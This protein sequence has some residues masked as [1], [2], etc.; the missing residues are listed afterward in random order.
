MDGDNFSYQKYR[1]PA[2]YHEGSVL[3]QP[4]PR[5]SYYQEEEL[6]YAV[7]SAASLSAASENKELAA[8]IAESYRSE[9]TA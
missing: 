9:I 5:L 3:D 1:W 7:S 6:L 8:L 2:F 4:H